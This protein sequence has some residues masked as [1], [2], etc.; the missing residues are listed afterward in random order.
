MKKIIFISFFTLL[1]GALSAQDLVSSF[2]K[3]H[4]ESDE[5]QVTTIGKKM[6][7]MLITIAQQGEIEMAKSL[8]GLDNIR[9]LSSSDTTKYNEYY[10]TA[11]DLIHKSRGF[12]IVMSSQSPGSNTVLAVKESKGIVKELVL[13]SGDE[14]TGNFNLISLTGKINLDTLAKYAGK[15]HIEGLDQLNKLRAN[16]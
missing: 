13:I 8:E 12:E 2:L 10:T 14:Q 16:E 1:T 5:F 3:K 4:N 9:A 15:L 6:L 11:C 7:D